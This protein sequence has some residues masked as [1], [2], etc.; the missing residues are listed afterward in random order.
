MRGAGRRV[1]V[2]GCTVHAAGPTTRTVAMLRM[3]SAC[4]RT[5][6][7]HLRAI[8]LLEPGGDREVPVVAAYARVARRG[9][10]LVRA[11]RRVRVRERVKVR[12]RERLRVRVRARVRTRVGARARVGGGRGADLDHAAAD[13]DDGDVEGA[14]TWLGL[15]LGLGLA[16]TWHHGRPLTRRR[17]A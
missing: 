16:T 9:D 12:V 14:T 4:A 11:R 6:R 3:C 2:A 7:A 10:D 5:K 17:A 13:V 1:Q 15:G 8:L